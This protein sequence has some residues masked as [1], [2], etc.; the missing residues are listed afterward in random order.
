VELRFYIGPETGRSHV[1]DHGVSEWEV[2]EVLYNPLEEFRGQRGSIVAI[3]QTRAGRYLKVIYV[4]DED[5]PDI[6]VVTAYDVSVKQRRA[7]KR[8][9]RRRGL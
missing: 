8:R 2:S 1:E 6:F 9:L 5:G 3:G 4:P 7:L